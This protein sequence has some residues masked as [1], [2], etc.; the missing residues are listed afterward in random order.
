M[1]HLMSRFERYTV[2]RSH[3]YSF[4][5]CRTRFGLVSGG[6]DLVFGDFVDF[7]VRQV[8]SCHAIAGVCKADAGNATCYFGFRGGL[9]CRER[10]VL[11]VVAVVQ[12][13]SA[14]EFPTG[15][16]DFE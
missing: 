12:G 3:N 9:V 4:S 13:G 11:S 6:L 16:L 15:H 10:L 7:S 14:V 1:A 8:D 5:L 2:G